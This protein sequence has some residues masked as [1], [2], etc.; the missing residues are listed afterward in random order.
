M[1]G[2]LVLAISSYAPLGWADSTLAIL[3]LRA[4][5]GVSFAMV[6]SAGSALAVDLAPESRR[7]EAVGYFGTAMLITNGFG[8]AI[9]ETLASVVSWRAVFVSC[10]LYSLGALCAALALRE[11]TARPGAT[12]STN[13]AMPISWPLAGAYLAAMAVGIGVGVSKT[14]IPAAL[15]EEG[16]ANVTPQ[17]VL[18]TVGALVQRTVLGWVPD[19]LG[20]LR[21]TVASIWLYAAVLAATAPIAAAW[22]PALAIVL[23]MAHGAAYP[24]A[25]AL[26]ADLCATN[27]RGRA[28]AWFAGFFN[29]GFAVAASGLPRLGTGFGYRGM[30]G[31]GAVLLAV[32]ALLI[33]RWVKSAAGP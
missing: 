14:F 6:F 11:S 9:A 17:F 31:A 30:I 18:Y 27:Q 26:T 4:L 23:G 1:L 32:A 7:A 24:A 12:T 20:R 2:G 25:T 22:I 13:Y 10:S 29:L 16:V 8:P 19:R 28:T 33:P 21:A 5:H 15:V 3:G